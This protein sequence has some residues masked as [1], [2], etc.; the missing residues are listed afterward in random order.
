MERYKHTQIGYV[1][2]PSLGAGTLI[3]LSILLNQGRNWVL[4]SVLLIL[5]SSAVL[6][7]SLTIEIKDGILK[8]HFGPGIIR[9]TVR[10][11]AR[12]TRRIGLGEY[13]IVSS[14]LGT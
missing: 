2:I 14:W 7:A 13:Y 8:I 12:A 6:F 11:A 1:T 3:V 10:S 9:K 4:L 5:A